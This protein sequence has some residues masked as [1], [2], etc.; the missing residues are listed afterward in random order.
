MGSITHKKAVVMPSAGEPSNVP[1]DQ[2]GYATR[3][4]PRIL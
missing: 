4:S 3:M 2:S 1:F